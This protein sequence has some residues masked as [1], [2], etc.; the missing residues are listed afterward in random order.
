MASP[1]PFI[2]TV[3]A[4]VT[5]SLAAVTVNTS[6]I[7]QTLSIDFYKRKCP[8]VEKIVSDVIKKNAL[9][10]KG[11]IP[12]IIRLHFHDC[13]I[14]GC[15]G[16]ILLTPERYNLYNTEMAHPAN[17]ISLRGMEV[18]NQ[19][20]TEVEKHC[21]NVVSCADILAYAARDAIVSVGNPHYVIP[22]GRR[23]G[24]AIDGNFAGGLPKSISNIERLTE[25]YAEKGLTVE[26]LVVLEGSH[27]IGQS[28]CQGTIAEVNSTLEVPAVD[29]FLDKSYK[30]MVENQSCAPKDSGVFWRLT[31]PLNPE[32]KV[33]EAWGVSFYENISKG[34][35]VLP[36]DLAMAV[37]GTT[38]DMVKQYASNA[39]L[40]KKKFNEAMIKLG[41]MNVLTGEQGEIRRHCGI[42]NSVNIP[43]KQ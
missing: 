20:K 1:L 15:D 23:D 43:V 18:I 33:N 6:A 31:T 13:F 2:V 28:R 32:K 10:N 35:G 12:G 4:I 3:L 36:S 7:I 29:N 25:Q 42:I 38:K 17:G 19:I 22:A 21:P 16:S 11:S 14:T 30:A 8:S 41:K 26:D 9:T 34:K 37:H 40:W 39:E 24:V 5:P 27:S